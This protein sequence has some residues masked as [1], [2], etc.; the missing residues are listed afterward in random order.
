MLIIVYIKSNYQS[1][2]VL[3]WK[4]LYFINLYIFPSQSCG[5]LVNLEA[6]A[7]VLNRKLLSLLAVYDTEFYMVDS[8]TGSDVQR[9]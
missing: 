2:K 6:V 7:A 4:H 9:S 1:D 8:T 5:V 3:R